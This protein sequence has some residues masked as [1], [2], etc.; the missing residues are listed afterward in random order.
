MTVRLKNGLE[1]VISDIRGQKLKTLLKE[2]TVKEEINLDG[3]GKMIKTAD[4]DLVYPDQTNKTEAWKLAIR[5]NLAIMRET[6][7][8]GKFTAYDILLE[9]QS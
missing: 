6:G 2:K 1:Y 5:R 3:N 8:I 7:K 9:Q 4:I